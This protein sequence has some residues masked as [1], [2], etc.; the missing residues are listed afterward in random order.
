M[1]V[2]ERSCIMTFRNQ[3]MFILPL[4][5]LCMSCA[6]D[7]TFTT[8][9]TSSS[10]SFRGMSVVDDDVAWISGSGGS[11]GRTTDGGKTW[12]IRVLDGYTEFGFRS[13]YAFDE[14]VAVAGNAGSPAYILRTEDGGTTWR[15]V[16][17]NSDTSAFIDGVDFWDD[18]N[19]VM[20]GD[21][22][23]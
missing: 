13:I 11:I 19:G 5:F 23:Q 22:I 9:T 15:E 20:Y 14:N 17:T 7:Y 6:Q 12:D 8:V 3:S 4:V 1:T 18:Q 2:Q 16:Y 21:P 10:A